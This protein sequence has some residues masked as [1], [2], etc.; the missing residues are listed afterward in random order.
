MFM[1]N[2]FIF[3]NT[4][5]F[6]EEIGKWL[7]LNKIPILSISEKGEYIFSNTKELK[8]KLKLLPDELKGG[9]EC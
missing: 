6:S 3:K 2:N 7:I 4:V 1:T 5:A 8:N 9:A